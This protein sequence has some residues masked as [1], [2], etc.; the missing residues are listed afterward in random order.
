MSV[1]DWFT[2]CPLNFV[3][4]QELQI[5]INNIASQLST[6]TTE[7]NSISEALNEALSA[8]N[9]IEFS[10]NNLTSSVT[11]LEGNVNF[12]IDSEAQDRQDII[13]IN[14]QL[15]Q[16]Q[17]LPSQVNSIQSSLDNFNI[18]N[19]HANQILQLDVN[20]ANLQSL[21]NEISSFQYA[22]LN[23]TAGVVTASTGLFGSWYQPIKLTNGNGSDLKFLILVIRGFYITIG[24]AYI[25]FW[26]DQLDLP[27]PPLNNN[28]YRVWYALNSPMCTKQAKYDFEFDPGGKFR[29]G[30]TPTV[31]DGIIENDS[32]MFIVEYI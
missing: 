18:I 7:V 23:F 9:N 17:G 10:L 8:I 5:D 6:L 28:D 13:G 15:Q 20:V 11:T 14:L 27:I 12:L 32:F 1:G 21:Y 24:F 4:K 30:V 19:Q 31:S 2:L 22:T 26:S 16:L 25:R 29:L 3:S